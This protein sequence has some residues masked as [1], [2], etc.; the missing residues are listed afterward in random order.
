[1]PLTLN[2]PPKTA[3][4]PITEVLHGVEIV[5][6]YRWLEDQTSSRTRGW[7]EDQTR[8]ARTYFDNLRGRQ[9]IRQRIREFLAIETYDSLQKFGNRYFFRKRLPDQEQPCICMREGANGQDEL[10]LDPGGK[11]SILCVP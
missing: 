4:E 3:V 7:L 6:P 9:A 10:L 8:Y 11:V 2:A 5:D 1:M